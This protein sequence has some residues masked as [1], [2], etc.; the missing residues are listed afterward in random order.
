M[1]MMLLMVTPY[2]L[3]VTSGSLSWGCGVFTSQFLL[4][5]QL[6]LFS[7]HS[8]ILDLL[9]SGLGLVVQLLASRLLRLL[10]VNVLHENSLVLEDITLAL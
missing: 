7:P 4:L 8:C 2:L 6:S 10:T 1:L 3:L 9:S 5:L